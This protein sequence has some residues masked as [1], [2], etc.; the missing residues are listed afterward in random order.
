LKAA[1][2]AHFMLATYKKLSIIFFLFKSTIC[3][4]VT[5]CLSTIVPYFDGNYYYGP[6]F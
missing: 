3:Q 4:L 6:Q 1:I 5:L 2:A